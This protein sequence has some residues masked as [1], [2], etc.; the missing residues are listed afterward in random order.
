MAA[1]LVAASLALPL[2]AVLSG[3]YSTG[4]TPVGGAAVPRRG[5]E[6][7]DQYLADARELLEEGLSDAA[8]ATFGLA[9]EE[10]PDLTE[11]YLE[12]ADIHKTR[13]DYRIAETNYDEAVRTDPNNFD[14]IY[15]SALM[16]HFTGRLAEAV[17]GYLLA[18]SIEPDSFEANRDLSAAYLQAGSPQQALP[19]ALAATNL[20]PDAQPAWSNLAVTY[21]MLGRWDD[22]I[23][24]YRLAAEL[25]PLDDPVLLGLAEAH[26]RLGN[27]GR[28]INTLESL[29]RRGD[30]ATGYE[31]TGYANFKLRRFEKALNFYD[32]A[33]G[34][35]P[36]NTAALNGKGAA[37]MTLF[38]EGKYENPYHKV[39][40][41][42][43]W[44]E[45][46]RL[47][48]EQPRIVDLLARY[49][50]K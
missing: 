32:R 47:A 26:I 16:K 8:L 42:E 17:R 21:A 18:L 33:I 45:S 2:S 15:G 31:R 19:Y 13:G 40:A 7:A 46:L 28:A 49:G 35:E 3:C 23:L 48:P 24:A 44:R 30:S 36:R 11:A 20:D 10:N 38:I 50:R 25:G 22:A 43:S 6:R 34:V 1:S 5:Q 27:Y 12:V 29:L 4:N 39:K 9:L 41:V 14:G 37:H